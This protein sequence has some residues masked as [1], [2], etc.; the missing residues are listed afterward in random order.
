MD[1]PKTGARCEFKTYHSMPKKNGAL[2]TKPEKEPFGQ[3]TV[4]HSEDAPFALVIH[5]KYTDKYELESTTLTVNSPH[6]LEVF[7]HVVGTSYTTVA[8]DF[9][10]PFDLSSPFQMLMH[11]VSHTDAHESH[12]V[13]LLA[14]HTP[15]VG[16]V[17][18]T[19][20]RNP[21]QPPAA[22]FEAAAGFHA[23]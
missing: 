10:T 11:Y 8:S 12:T 4:S 5:R 23:A 22:T 21:R 7:R 6:L 16:R 15:A 2:E 19:P 14:H 9:K 17:R 1:A 18:G 3:V 20:K 13:C